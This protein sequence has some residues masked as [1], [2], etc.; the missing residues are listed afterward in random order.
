MGMVQFF[1][2]SAAH[3]LRW[4]AFLLIPT[5]VHAGCVVDRYGNTLCPPARAACV[6]DAHGDWH[7]GPPGGAALLDR[8][9]KPVCG[10]G[11]CVVDIRGEQRCASVPDGQAALDRYGEA[12]CSASCVAAESSRC[13]PLRR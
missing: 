12:V 10:I 4:V 1:N 9:G 5:A 2:A 3:G 6:K 8:H 11:H 7:C 13:Q